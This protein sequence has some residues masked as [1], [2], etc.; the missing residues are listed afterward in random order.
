[1]NHKIRVVSIIF[2]V[3]SFCILLFYNYILDPSGTVVPLTQYNSEEALEKAISN[4]TAIIIYIFAIVAVCIFYLIYESYRIMYDELANRMEMLDASRDDLQ[5]TYDS[6]GIFFI[7]V[8]PE[9]TILNINSAFSDSIGKRKNNIIGKNLFSI[10]DFGVNSKEMLGFE[11][12]K[13]FAC[14]SNERAELQNRGKIYEALIFHLKEAKDRTPKVLLMLNDVTNARAIE[15][16]MLQDNK[17]IAVGQLAAGVAHEIRNP[18]GIIRNYCYVLKNSGEY[19]RAVI[20]KAISSIEKAVDRSGRII[21]NLLD[22]SRISNNKRELINVKR[23]MKSIVLLEQ[24]VLDSKR[25]HVEINC[26]EDIEF[27]TIVESL[28]II[29][30]NLILNAIDAMPKGGEL[31][32]TCSREQDTLAILV[33]DPG[34]GIPEENLGS[35]FNPFFTTKEK[36]DGSGLGLYIVYNETEK[37]GGKIE[38]LSRLGV[39]TTFTFTFPMQRGEDHDKQEI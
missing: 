12:Q 24:S 8:D 33:S 3:A 4:R 31:S 13:A 19:D 26:G 6:V 34:I 14:G 37:L 11:I 23:F 30:I 20:E 32:I 10:L 2:I 15:R 25:I 17:M 27:L 28:E 36:R 22:F 7:E 18:L 16:Q 39:G 9:L 35:I 5:T 38:V 1:M 29:I 21:D